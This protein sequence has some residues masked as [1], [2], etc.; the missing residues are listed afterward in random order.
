[1]NICEDEQLLILSYNQENSK[2]QCPNCLVDVLY[3]DKFCHSCG[4]KLDF[5]DKPVKKPVQTDKSDDDIVLKYAAVNLLNRLKYDPLYE[6]NEAFYAPF[7]PFTYYDVITY[8]VNNN[9]VDALIGE[10]KV[11]VAL[12]S[13]PNEFLEFVLD[14]KQINKSSSK[15][16][17]IR[18]IRESLSIE[19]V[20]GMFPGCYILT[21]NGEEVLKDNI[22]CLMY[23]SMYYD[24]DILY[25]DNMYESSQDKNK[26]LIDLVNDSIEDSVEML[27]WQSY[28]DLLFRYAQVYDF[29]KDYDRM[30]YYAIGHFICEFGLFG[31]NCIKDFIKIDITIKNK[32]KYVLAR[33]DKS[34]DEFISV[35]SEVY[36][37]LRIPRI[38]ISRE[39]VCLLI[40]ELFDENVKLRHANN[41]LVKL[42]GRERIKL[43][44]MSFKNSAEQEKIMEELERLF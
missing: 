30:L 17:N 25:Y 37:N 29:F 4:I 1:M 24:F 41:H 6:G 44:K 33:A 14:Q 16:D 7:T 22:K 23:F 31:N 15:Q 39:D 40:E 34:Y 10:E 11:H 43:K 42:Y 36:D 5:D 18:I 13:V 20:E 12:E 26:F 21:T 35:V 9:L 38:F 3:Y 19:E 8:L 2:V 32:I 27:Q 28:S